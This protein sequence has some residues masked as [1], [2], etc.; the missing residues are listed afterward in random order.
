MIILFPIITGYAGISF[1][2]IKVPFVALL[3]NKRKLKFQIPIQNSIPKKIA[4]D[5]SLFFIG[6]KAVPKG[7]DDMP[8]LSVVT[9]EGLHEAFIKLALTKRS[10]K[11]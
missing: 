4:T 8:T 6:N 10:N 9:D 11:T 7:L 1:L 3:M 5:L 2:P